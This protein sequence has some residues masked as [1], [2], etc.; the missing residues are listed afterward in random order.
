MHKGMVGGVLWRQTN[1]R[2][3]DLLP[4]RLEKAFCKRE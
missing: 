1:K 3:W 2:A 4:K